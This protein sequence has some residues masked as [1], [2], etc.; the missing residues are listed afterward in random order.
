MTSYHIN[1]NT[2]NPNICSDE[3]QCKFASD[4]GTTPPH[5]ETQVEAKKAVAEQIFAAFS[6]PQ[7][8]NNDSENSA[9]ESNESNKSDEDF[10]GSEKLEKAIEFARKLDHSI[11]LKL[12]VYRVK[13]DSMRNKAFKIIELVPRP[14]LLTRAGYHG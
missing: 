14:K 1:P 2:G 12:P 8:V 10:R 7:T 4:E 6:A 5:F 11:A 3:S 9:L 13:L